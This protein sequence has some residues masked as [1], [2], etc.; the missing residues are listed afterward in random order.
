MTEVF[1]G[2]H[3]AHDPTWISR[4]TDATRQAERFRAG[5]VLLAGDA[6]HVHYP[7][8]GQGLSLG[9]Q[10]AVDLGWKLALVVRG[11]APEA[12][13]DTYHDDRH[14]AV[15]TTLRHTLALGA[16]Q[17]RDDRTTVL[18]DL[19]SELAGL[20][21]SRRLLVA[22]TSGLDVRVDL[23]DGH[24][25][26][27]R[28]MPDVDLDTP[29][30]PRRVFA[31]LHDARPLLLDLGGADG[32]VAAALAG[33]ERVRVVAARTAGPWTM[34]VIGA[35]PAPAAV[36]VRPDGVVAWVG[37]GSTAGLDDALTRW[38]GPPRRAA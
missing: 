35:V 30:G 13:I 18:A 27:G 19:V 15:A 10:D 38:F 20:D 4:F 5:R 11:R 6:A 22:R 32:A 26:L 33:D 2:G 29:E 28:R 21:G 36:L 34:P 17:R 24:P 14:P 37:D 31:L 25:L 16:L 7:V 8:G 3:G 1:G 12:L 9:I 23:G